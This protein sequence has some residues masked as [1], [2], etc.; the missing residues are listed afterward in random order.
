MQKEMDEIDPIDRTAEELSKD[1][2][3]ELTLG[4][5]KILLATDGSA[6]SIVATKYAIGMAKILDAEIIAVF[7]DELF[8]LLPEERAEEESFE[9]VKY[10]AAGLQVAKWYGEKNGVNVRTIAK[11]GSAPKQIIETAE[12]EN[13]DLIVLGTTGRTGLRRIMIGSA[14]E[15]VVKASRIP[16]LIAR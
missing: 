10:T 6:P 9:R 1:D 11:K 16:V 15:K 5:K 12:R 2:V 13:A 14:A 4:I 8:A 7:V 3:T